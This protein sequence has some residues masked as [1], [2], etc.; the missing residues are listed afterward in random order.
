MPV[1]VLLNGAPASGKSILARLWAEQRP[2]ALALDIDVVRS[3]LSSWQ[4]DPEAAGRAAR[5]LAVA[6]I[7]VQLERGR[8][9]IVPQ[10]VAR[11][12][13]VDRLTELAQRHRVPFVH[14]VV[15]ERAEIAEH[16][17]RARVSAHQGE[18]KRVEPVLHGRLGS[19]PMEDLIAAHERFIDQRAEAVVVAAVD[20]DLPESLHRLREAIE[21]DSRGH[22]TP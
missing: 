12:A 6:M 21:R 9:V 19:E 7:G 16:R 20:G 22:S 4:D 11:A 5:D 1:L 15:R 8:D 2:L 18:L 3:M 17:F 10:Y 13:F 14:I